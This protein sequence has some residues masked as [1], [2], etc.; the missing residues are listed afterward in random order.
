M[1]EEE[2]KEVE[3][4][5]EA[6]I[7]NPQE[8]SPATTE[9]KESV[10]VAP[11]STPPQPQETP[12]S[13]NDTPKEEVSPLEQKEEEPKGKRSMI[14]VIIL[15]IVI[16]GFLIFLPKI[17]DRLTEEQQRKKLEQFE[18]A[19][20]KE[21]EELNKKE[22]QEEE[23]EEQY[24]E[25]HKTRNFVCTLSAEAIPGI[26]NGT[27]TTTLEILSYGPSIQQY[28]ETQVESFPVADA[29]FEK[30]WAECNQKLQLLTE[31][32]VDGYEFAC[33]MDATTITKVTK[34][35]LDLFT[36]ADLK[37]PDGREEF[38]LSQFEMEEEIETAIEKLNALNYVC[39]EQEENS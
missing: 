30:E 28:T 23:E 15:F 31:T 17:S 3:K 20:K 4:R 10:S 24:E 9:P 32:P 7:Q 34:Y 35:E 36:G 1:N 6:P 8:V 2:K 37:Y 18:Q 26:E 39:N 33:T 5:E 25:S 29:N 14:P 38:L 22:E 16:G 12:V 19:L 11:T 27:K 21:Q 13:A